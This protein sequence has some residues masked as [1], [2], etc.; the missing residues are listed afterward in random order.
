MK[1][2]HSSPVG[3]EAQTGPLFHLYLQESAFAFLTPRKLADPTPCPEHA[4]FIREFNSKLEAA[5]GCAA[6]NEPFL[7]DRLANLDRCALIKDDLYWLSIAR[8]TELALLCAG[9]YADACEFQLVGDLLLNPRVIYVHVRGEDYPILKHRHEALT[10]QFGRRGCSTSDVID[11]LKHET[12]L[13]LKKEALLPYLYK[14]MEDAGCFSEDYLESIRM[15]KIRIASLIA[16]LTNVSLSDAASMHQWMR[17]ASPKDRKM[18]ESRLCRFDRGMFL[19]LGLEIQ[20]KTG[21]EA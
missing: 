3:L 13:E 5:S 2:Y 16:F 19:N 14:Q 17:S 18:L 21:F 6:L 8:L 9:N 12:I 10:E 20:R 1:G 11:W 15:R 4:A 7:E